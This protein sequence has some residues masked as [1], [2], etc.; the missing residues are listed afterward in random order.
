MRITA[1]DHT[2]FE[3]FYK[4]VRNRL[5]LQTW[6]LTGDLAAAEKAVRD[7]FVVAWHHWRKLRRLSDRAREDWV[8]PVAWQRAQRRHSVPHLH[9]D[10]G[11]DPEVRATLVA[12]GKLPVAQRKVL[13]LSTLATIDFDTLSREV[14]LPKSRTELMLQSSTAQFSLLRD[15][16]STAIRQLFVPMADH[17]AE[18]PWPRATIITRAGA[19]RRRTHTLAGAVAAC[20]ALLVS[21]VFVSHA[22]TTDPSL[23]SLSLHTRPT[24]SAPAPVDHHYP[25]GPAQLLDDATVTSALPGAWSTQLTSDSG[26]TSLPCAMRSSADKHPD[27][28]L[29]RTFTGPHAK[30]LVTTTVTASASESDAEAA[31]A[32]TLD[33][34]AGCTA[35]RLQLVDT[36]SVSGVGDQAT[37]F[38]LR[39]WS[40]PMRSLVVGVARSGSL[41]TAVA[42]SIPVAAHTALALGPELLI[43]AVRPVCGLPGAGACIGTPR[44]HDEPSLPIGAHPGLLDVV[45]LPPAAT[46]DQPWV[47]TAPQDASTNPA[48]SHCD[49]TDFDTAAVSG[50]LT[51]TFLVA[52]DSPGVR[53]GL[54][55]T[56]GLLRTPRAASAFVSRIESRLASCSHRELGSKAT[57]MGTPT[58]R[59]GSTV[60]LWN[61]E[62]GSKSG[63]TT[64]LM[65][66]VRRGRAVSQLSFVPTGRAT[67]D[68]DAFAAIAQR[69]AERLRYLTS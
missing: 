47:T 31:Y 39:D 60:S 30:D 65:A 41:T 40:A 51:R 55:Q 15:V 64:Y 1:D 16:G 66:L 21:G 26:T 38:A 56:V 53:F 34:L 44:A 52:K 27:A 50:D 32:T 42:A 68:H 4:D 61:V 54:T 7:A 23:E 6:A 9:R 45:D 3:T 63:T 11:I 37:L 59:E 25:L 10:R 62:V 14:G 57:R 13:L 17:L 22:A 36:Q 67:I 49:E 12:L 43:R 28:T 46:V 58:T 5:L 18:R 33:W 48:A 20:V 8:R 35:P 19:G 29:A 2:A 24:P 69:A